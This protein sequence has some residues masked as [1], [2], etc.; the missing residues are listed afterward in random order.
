M[1]LDNEALIRV[2]KW[3][4]VCDTESQ[5][6]SADYDLAMQIAAQAGIHT[7]AEEYARY[8]LQALDREAARRAA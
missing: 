7:T 3:A 8:R 5:M 2:L 1:Q 6:N 4:W